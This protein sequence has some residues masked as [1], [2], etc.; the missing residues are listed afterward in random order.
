[1]TCGRLTP[2]KTSSTVWVYCNWEDRV[3]SSS[4]S[5]QKV[6]ALARGL[7]QGVAHRIARSRRLDLHVIDRR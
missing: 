7:H 1:M 3:S 6:A 5:S 2:S 4:F